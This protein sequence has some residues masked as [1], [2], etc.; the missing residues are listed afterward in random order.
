M[1][2]WQYA[3]AFVVGEDIKGLCILIAGHNFGISA[4]ILADIK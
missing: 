4:Q 1:P 2:E 3:K